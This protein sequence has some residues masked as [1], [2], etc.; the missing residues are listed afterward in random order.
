MLGW[1]SFIGI[2]VAL[3]VFF[4]AVA[5]MKHDYLDLATSDAVRQGLVIGIAA[6]GLLLASVAVAWWRERSP[7]DWDE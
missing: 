6:D 2:L 3:P 1:P 4:A 5:W 7:R